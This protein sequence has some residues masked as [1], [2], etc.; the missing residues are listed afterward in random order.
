MEGLPIGTYYKLVNL[1]KIQILPGYVGCYKIFVKN[2]H[3]TNLPLSSL[4]ENTLH[5]NGKRNVSMP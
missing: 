5:I 2:Y 1:K 4:M 3:K